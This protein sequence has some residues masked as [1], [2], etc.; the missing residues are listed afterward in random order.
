MA[1]V[2]TPFLSLGAS[3]SIA[4][5]LTAQR[6]RSRDT[7]RSMPVPTNPRSPAQCAHRAIVAKAVHGW[8]TTLTH[9]HNTD[10]SAA[11]GWDRY[12]SATKS[13]AAGYHLAVKSMIAVY[14]LQD[15]AQ[16]LSYAHTI[17]GEMRYTSKDPYTDTFVA[18]AANV[19]CFGG[20]DPT[21]L[22]WIF[23]APL[24]G[25]HSVYPAPWPYDALDPY[26]IQIFVNGLPRSGVYR[27]GKM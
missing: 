22:V 25:G 14:S 27:L 3:G 6:N 11:P 9:T 15:T 10:E 2:K 21:K 12:A 18:E 19:D 8:Q 24:V 26:Y 20:T 4:N 23:A 17:A 1:I 5:T 16:Y 7:M 13:R